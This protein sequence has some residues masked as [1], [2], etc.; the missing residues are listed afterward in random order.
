MFPTFV[1][2]GIVGR[3]KIGSW[4]AGYRRIKSRFFPGVRIAGTVSNALQ[5]DFKAFFWMPVYYSIRAL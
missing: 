3:W 5:S 1:A 2:P 4:P